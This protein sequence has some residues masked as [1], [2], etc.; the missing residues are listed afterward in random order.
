MADWRQIQ[1]RI[2]K[3][4]S[5][6]DPQAKLSDLY[7]RTRDA[8]V[9]W[10]LGAV[11]EKA[12]NSDEAAKW[13][14]TA[15]GRFR[16]SDWKKKAEEALARLGVEVPASESAAS[17]RDEEAEAAGESAEF[18]PAPIAIDSARETRA[19][20]L[21]ED[22]EE[23]E[24][25]TNLSAGEAAPGPAGVQGAPTGDTPGKKKRRRGRRGGKGRGKRGGAPAGAPGLPPSAFAENTPAGNK[26]PTELR[27]E[28]PS[29]TP[30]LTPE[31]SA[32]ESFVERRRLPEPSPAPV[33][34]RQPLQMPMAPPQLPS[35]RVTHG[36][37]DPGLTSRLAHLE[38]MLRRLVSSAMH[39][40]DE[41]DE[42]PAG[43]GV[44]LL[45]E[46]DQ[47]TSYYV[48]SCQTLRIGLGNLTRSSGGRN[49][50]GRGYGGSET[51]LK[52]RLAEHLGIN[53][54]KVAQYMK[55]HCAVRWI[56]LDDEAPY[57]AQFAIGVLRTP[58]NFE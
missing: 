40:L 22:S 58:L 52:A 50:R 9:A 12:G 41:A 23:E 13:Y 2:R 36:R 5:S 37:S 26:A 57:L 8:M 24:G 46:G 49:Q 20:S 32:P 53:E 51:S 45:S 48:E 34:P 35:E 33:E 17:H 10:E 47:T 55:D 42:A 25:M 30:A 56:Q 16:R 18:A 6:A 39:R 54:A 3:A 7:Q 27:P 29:L 19:S 38:S 14:V 4:K 43:P 31:R 44:F 1:A 28:R 11:M 15:H 21:F